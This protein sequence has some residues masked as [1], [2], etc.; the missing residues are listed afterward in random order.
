M[1]AWRPA[2]ILMAAGAALGWWMFHHRGAALFALVGLA[3]AFGFQMLARHSSRLAV[4]IA[5]AGS[6]LALHSSSTLGWAGT[7]VPDGSRFKAS[8]VGLSHVLT[9]D[10]LESETMDCGWYAASNY[11][12][13]CDVADER[14]FVRLRAVYPLILAA[15]G[16]SL[17]GAAAAALRS[18]RGATAGR[19]AGGA[20]LIALGGLVLFALS[21]R[22]ALAPIADL[23]VGVG[24][25]LGT[26]QLS[27]ALLLCFAAAAPG[28]FTTEAR[29]GAKV[30]ISDSASTT[31]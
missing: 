21:V 20:G 29:R 24:G 3:V 15:A 18:R 8:P 9:P 25:T 26:M 1:R 19:L 4:A 7:D 27:L 22:P 23:P 2:L 16:L 12:T 13:A 10:R 11:P 14:A 31:P 6:A 30:R 5:L 17:A 28:E